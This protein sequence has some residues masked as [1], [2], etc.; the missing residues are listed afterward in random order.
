M[1]VRDRAG[2]R[3]IQRSWIGELLI[4]IDYDDTGGP[5][6]S[7]APARPGR[8]RELPTR[9]PRL[10]RFNIARMSNAEL[11]IGACEQRPASA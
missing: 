5:N 4:Y 6:D 9:S 7:F 3:T 2:F 8:A 11:R 1:K 10:F